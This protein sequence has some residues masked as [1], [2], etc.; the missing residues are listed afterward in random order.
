MIPNLQCI[1]ST[2]MPHKEMNSSKTRVAEESCHMLELCSAAFHRPMVIA[3]SQS[4]K[5][6]QLLIHLMSELAASR[7]L[8][9]RKLPLV[10]H[11]VTNGMVK[12]RKVSAKAIPIHGVD[13]ILLDLMPR[14]WKSPNFLKLEALRKLLWRIIWLHL[15]IKKDRIWLKNRCKDKGLS[16]V[17]FF[18]RNAD[19]RSAPMMAATCKLMSRA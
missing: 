11:K 13:S 1:R 5:T 4:R 14:I 15:P 16:A 9:L 18:N 6:Y 2:W 19:H 7:I 8:T 17:K 10:Q 3:R 12:T